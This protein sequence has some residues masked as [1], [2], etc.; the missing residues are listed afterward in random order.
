MS[1]KSTVARVL[2][3]ATRGESILLSAQLERVDIKTMVT[4]DAH[5]DG[6]PVCP[7]VIDYIIDGVAVQWMDA[8]ISPSIAMQRAESLASAL[9][10]PLCVIHTN[11]WHEVSKLTHSLS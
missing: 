6:K 1:I 8:K 3:R 5:F 2:D 10:I 9:L 4:V 11:G 7:V